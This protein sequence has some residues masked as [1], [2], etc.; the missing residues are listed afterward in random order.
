MP[1]SPA[2][3]LLLFAGCLWAQSDRG[4]ITGTV[5]DP[6]GAVLG[7][8]RI[9][10]RSRERG[11]VYTAGSSSTG[12]YT[13]R[14]L[15]AG[16]YELTVSR[17]GFKTLRQPN[18]VLPVAQTLRV[19]VTLE[20]GATTEA[21]T[22]SGAPSL[23]QTESGELA[24]HV[25]SSLLNNLP[26][27][28]IGG[29]NGGARNALAL[30]RL[31]PASAYT[32]ELVVRLNGL[33]AN[34]QSVRIQGQEAQTS[35]LS[36]NQTWTQPSVDAIQEVAVQTSNYAAEFGQAGGGLLNVTMRSGTNQMHGSAYDYLRNEALNA[37][38]PNTVQPGRPN[39]HRRNRVR[40]HDFGFNYGGPVRVPGLY[41][42]RNRTFIF[43]NFEQ[44]RETVVTSTQVRTVP[45]NEYRQ[46]DFRRA[47]GP[48]QAS[49][50]KA[51]RS[52]QQ[53][54]LFDPFSES[55]VQAPP[56]SAAC[57]LCTGQ[58]ERMRQPFAIN[59]V[60]PVSYLDPVALAVQSFMPA[61]DNNAL[62]VNNYTPVFENARR[63]TLPSL[64]LDQHVTPRAK[65]NAYYGLTAV[66][67]P[68]N[69]GMPVP[70]TARRATDVVT[71]TLRLN[72]DY[73]LTPTLLLH[74]GAGYLQTTNNE[75]VPRFDVTTLG[76]NGRG[77]Q[78]T[79]GGPFMYSTNAGNLLGGQ[80]GGYDR[81]IGPFTQNRLRN[82]KPTANASLSWVRGNHTLKAGG[83]LVIDGF[84]N[85]GNSY[86][87]PLIN[88]SANNVTT[89]S[90][91]GTALAQ[92]TGFAYA[93]F[94]M[95]RADNGITAVP[96]STRLGKHALAGF[97]QDNWKVTRRLTLDYGLRYDFQT[98]YRENHGLMPNLGPA[99]P[100]P[101]ADGRLGGTIF[102]GYEAG[103][104]QCWFAR[105][106]P[107]AFGPRLAAAFQLSPKTVVRAGFGLTYTRTAAN[108]LQSY[109]IGGQL[110]YSTAQFGDPVF[111]LKDGLPF[112]A[113]YPN[114]DPGQ[115][116]YLGIPATALNF[117]DP[118]AG[119]PGRIAQWSLMLERELI[120]DV[121]LEAGYVA[122]RGA[123]F[124]S[125]A[126]VC[127]T[128]LQPG[129]LAKVGLDVTAAADQSLLAAQLNSTLAR[130]RGFSNPPY[131]RFPLTQTVRQ[132]LNPY[133]MFTAINR[134]WAPLGSTWFDSLQVNL[135]QRSRFGLDLQAAFTWSRQFM[136][137]AEHEFGQVAPLQTPVNDVFNRPT[138]KYLSGYDQPLQV[139]VSGV[140]TTPRWSAKAWIQRLL[141][142]WQISA[143][144][145]YASG[146]PV[147]VPA[148]NN[149]LFSHL[150][151]STFA[152]RVAGQPVYLRDPNCKCFDPN[153]ELILN[154][155][156]WSNPPRGAFGSAAA[157]YNDFRAVRRPEESAALARNFHL[158][159]EGRINLHL[160]LEFNNI[161]NRWSWPNPSGNPFTSVPTRD[162]AGNLTGGFGFVDIRS[163]QGANPRSAQLIGRFT[164]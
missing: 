125:A 38:V 4:A 83:E 18:I 154:P 67:M 11:G 27:L 123:W 82:L 6:T 79:G 104:C 108:N 87:S 146:L 88:F 12:N 55:L 130:Q 145:R 96:S 57:P 39:Q 5:S 15:P 155:A 147:R 49:L 132:A 17:D 153:Q 128:C 36:F 54:Q 90:V 3:L 33:P 99:T 7:G 119:R 139:V 148:A 30:V 9:E 71:H 85:R 10:A 86:A 101:I 144:M 50:D 102:E 68:N 2:Y 37:G 75:A 46:G 51:G 111:L 121:T 13:I 152:D 26:V 110:N 107:L 72:F 74:L 138:L 95:G 89:P 45:V 32:P 92:T 23:L 41:D 135:T 16:T 22:V 81:A 133:P 28:T 69:D 78:G 8:A 52:V 140:Y 84:V 1:K 129:E 98:Y 103:R 24:F 112:R 97:M 137:G 56:P 120:R 65:L 131:S 149:A 91:Q 20:L 127:D 160:R 58:L 116:P 31:L 158:E 76:N 19:D 105:N 151:R 142:D 35:M 94:L 29:V 100:N 124:P 159:P 122:N 143:V 118:N 59:N 53:N 34:T 117:I 163:G 44:F 14:E 64:N 80:F 126:L 42:G 25:S 66:Y 21:I 157:Y 113:R 136:R 156:A 70:I 162:A 60:V 48:V 109:A 62:L 40:Q 141:R 134:S 115:L 114:L 61:P 43:F 73:T 164:F 161:F 63:Q 93:S 47:L 106:Y 150:G 77:L